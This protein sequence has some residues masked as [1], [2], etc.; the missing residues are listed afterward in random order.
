[1]L[2]KEDEA[3]VKRWEKQRIY[4]R[5]WQNSLRKGLGMGLMMSFPIVLAV[6]FR[7]WYKRMP[8]VSGAQ[9]FLVIT[10]CLLVSVFYALLK[11]RMQWE[12]R[13]ARYRQLLNKNDNTA[14]VK[15]ID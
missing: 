5:R 8:F 10:A 11:G 9:L 12:E 7:G 2:G 1:M 15:E 14:Q 3:F 13:E 4:E 6:L